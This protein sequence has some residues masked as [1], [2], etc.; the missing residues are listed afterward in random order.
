MIRRHVPQIG[1]DLQ[2]AGEASAS[3]DHPEEYGV[4]GTEVLL[5]EAPIACCGFVAAGPAGR[6]LLVACLITPY[7]LGHTDAN[8]KEKV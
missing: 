6:F 1:L 8:G 7:I 5:P 4:H 3:L 2:V